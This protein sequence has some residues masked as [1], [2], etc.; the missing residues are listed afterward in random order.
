MRELSRISKHHLHTTRYTINRL[1]DRGILHRAWIID[2]FALGWQRVQILCST[3]NADRQ[4]VIA[5]FTGRSRVVHLAEIGGEYDFD[6]VVLARGTHDTLCLMR[7][8]AKACGDIFAS[9]ALVVQNSISYFPRKYLCRGR[10]SC[11][12]L[13]T[14]GEKPRHTIDEI[15]HRILELLMS[16]PAILKKEMGERLSLSLPTVSA[17]LARLKEQG[18]LV[19]AMFS[20][21]YS[22]L[23]VQNYK[24]LISSRDRSQEFRD[25]LYD[26]AYRHPHCTSYRDSIG[27]WDYELNAEVESHGELTE[28]KNALYRRFGSG[29]SRLQVIPR[30]KMHKFMSY[31]VLARQA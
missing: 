9:K 6:I 14:G 12:V 21:R 15:D 22:E 5:F 4:K 11:G 23:G 26:F 27:E 17:R 7:D 29:T 8:A 10:V 2:V 20:P 30:F 19:G 25:A 13:V 16:T 24:L 31:P 18:V 28:L 3:G 1:E